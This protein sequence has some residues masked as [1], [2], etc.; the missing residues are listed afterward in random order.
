MASVAQVIGYSLFVRQCIQAIAESDLANA[1]KIESKTN[2]LFLTYLS[3]PLH[4]TIL[5]TKKSSVIQRVLLSKNYL[6]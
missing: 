2:L 1:H 3:V 4:I 6:S 5:I